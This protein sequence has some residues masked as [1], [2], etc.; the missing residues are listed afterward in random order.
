MHAESLS[1]NLRETLDLF[2]PGGAPKTTP[3]VTAQLGLGRRGTYAR[4]EQ[5]ADRHLL[6]TK[7]V[8]ANARVWWRPLRRDSDVVIPKTIVTDALDDVG[9]CLLDADEEV[10]W[11]N[12][13]F[14]Q[15][16][17]LERATAIGRDRQ[18][19]A[20]EFG[21]PSREQRAS[22]GDQRSV[23]DESE[24]ARDE[25]HVTPKNDPAERSL[26][27]RQYPIE[28]G[29]FAGGRL[30]VVTEISPQSSS[31]D[32]SSLKN[33]QFASLVDAVEEYAVFRLDTDG[34]IETW[35]TGAEQIKG[36]EAGDVLGEHI[37]LFYT[38]A[39][40]AAG[41]PE[42]NL[43]K[44]AA[45]GSY[46]DEGWRVRGDGSTFW[47][48]I[49]LT[50]I[51][52]DAGDVQ[53]FLK[54]TRDM[55]TRRE[56]ERRLQAQ[57]ARLERQRDELASELDEVFDRI[58]D[59]F[60]ALD[61]SYRF[62]Y[63]NDHAKEVL[64]VDDSVVGAD[65]RDVVPT[66]DQFEAALEEALESQE[67]VRFE[68]YYEPVD[69]WFYNAIYP[70]ESG[71]SVYFRDITDE[72]RH[73]F[74]L[75]RYQ[76]TVETVW[77]GIVTLDADDRFVMVNE[78]FSE[79]SGY[80]R[81]ELVGK[82][83]TRL[84]DDESYESALEVAEEGDGPD[85]EMSTMEFELQ[86][87][88]GETVPV[89]VRFGPIVFDD[90]TVGRTAVVR[91]ISERKRRE[92]ELERQREIF[93]YAEQLVGIGGWETDVETGEQ[94]WTQGLFEIHDLDGDDQQVP[95]AD[96]YISMVVPEQREA[97][98]TVATACME[99]GEPYDEEIRIHTSE[100]NERWI[101]TV[102]APIVE[103]GDIVTL[104]GAA[105]D[106]TERKERERLLEAQQEMNQQLIETSPIGITVVDTCGEIQF[107][108]NRATELFGR[109]KD[110]LLEMGYDDPDWKEINVE[111]EEISEDERPL[112]R[113]LKSREPLFDHVSGLVGPGGE[114][115]WISVNGAPLTD[116]AG[117][118]VGV[119]FAI[120]DVTEQFEH[121]R[122]LEAVNAI[123]DVVN[124]IT[125]TIIE[126]STR[127]AIEQAVCE[128]LAAADT[129]EF[130]WL[131]AVDRSTGELET[132][133]AAGTSG[134]ETDVTV[135]MDPDT[136]ESQG[137]GAI[138][139]R[140]QEPQIVQDVYED[141]RF[142]PWR[143]AAN[144]Y[145]FTAVASIPIVHE[146]TVYGVLGV[147]A[148]RENA[149]DQPEQRIISQLG[150]VV[151]HAI[152]ATDRKRALTSDELIELE[153]TIQDV[154]EV[155][156]VPT[157]P[158]GTISLEYAVPTGDGEFL[159]YGTAAG[160]AIETV[161]ELVDVVPHWTA[162]TIREAG[163]PTGFEVQMSDP[164]IL[165]VVSD[166]GGYLERFRI[167]DGEWKLT[168]HLAPTVDVRRVID[169]VADAYP[170]AEM[171]RRQQ[172]T[173]SRNDPQRMHRELVHDLTDRQRTVL[174]AAYHAGFF[175][176]PRAVDGSELAASI[177]IAPPTFHQHLRRAQKKVFDT[178]YSTAD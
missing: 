163:D 91:D 159:V 141:P 132:R 140:E 55:T 110:E 27:H 106:I 43:A 75:E 169:A 122:E 89:E 71:L 33:E 171:V 162:V 15:L 85:G 154:F 102:G 62:R 26:E 57:A 150:E 83:A 25:C 108:N 66:T 135:T 70:S 146:G 50:A 93:R 49:T 65:F 63:L 8:G 123:N 156:D 84:I 56:Y 96:E 121:E 111:G 164:P 174:D 32:G 31:T 81:E 104:R 152:A 133:A 7:K 147:Y 99:E 177:G 149:F 19:L 178:V 148:D 136:A 9:L 129:Y 5:L 127:E 28:S 2:E 168:V 77:D 12:D 160:D 67:P 53:G 101:R 46:E 151:G 98:R 95:T 138:A 125:T 48:H 114:V 39:D 117:G 92:R 87:N 170:A 76:T 118:I 142:E 58:D 45:N 126:Q 18:E 37:S 4:L 17:G 47:A 175:E 60:Y 134:Y 167:E 59:G 22:A 130:A 145:G 139:I 97:F 113:I 44:A 173:R 1:E 94:R 35:N 3:E 158:T 16:L 112:P 72:K 64:S 6:H 172:I 86:A 14:E 88:G 38:A 103:D 52:D 30:D 161:S 41:V 79:M 61:E 24:V 82:H 51:T 124:E 21:L 80:G 105:I 20:S 100:G 157:R 54:V 29:D 176:W 131:A 34:H 78:A 69:R 109:T 11:V 143:G 40:G 144:E 74:E 42:A 165:S 23:T 107:V 153:F 128:A 36:Y 10:V 116:E 137:P 13:A 119:V 68:E 73:E 115:T 166:L 120:E 90:G 155:I